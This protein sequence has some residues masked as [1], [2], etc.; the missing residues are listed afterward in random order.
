MRSFRQLLGLNVIAALGGAHKPVL[1]PVK[2]ESGWTM[3]IAARGEI[4]T[5][6]VDAGTRSGE[7]LVIA[8][9]PPVI[10]SPLSSGGSQSFLT[11]HL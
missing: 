7:P 5:S 6:S 11:G 10:T 2:V 3:E 4:V 8:V 9:R 1:V